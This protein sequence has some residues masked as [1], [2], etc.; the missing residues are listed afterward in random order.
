MAN[1][2]SKKIAFEIYKPLIL[3]R[4]LLTF[5]LI[6]IIDFFANSQKE[7]KR[8]FLQKFR[9]GRISKFESPHVVELHYV[10]Q[11]PEMTAQRLRSL[12]DL[13]FLCFASLIK[14]VWFSRV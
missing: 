6:S 7:G 10:R 13:I 2:I 8:N 5:S 3:D 14:A 9:L 1:G 4:G 12:K 11:N